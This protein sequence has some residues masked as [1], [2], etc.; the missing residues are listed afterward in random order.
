MEYQKNNHDLE[1]LVV[2]C[3]FMHWLSGQACPC[4]CGQVLHPNIREKFSRDLTLMSW[5]AR[6]LE[7]V[8]PSLRW[9]NLTECVHEFSLSMTKQVGDWTDG[10]AWQCVCMSFLFPCPI[11]FS[12]WQN[13]WVNHTQCMHKFFVSTTELMGQ[14]HAVSPWLNRRV[15]LTQCLH[16]LCE[17]SLSI[18]KQDQVDGSTSCRVCIHKFSLSMIKQVGQPHAA[19]AYTSFLS[20]WSNRWANLMQH[21]YR[22]V[23]S[24]HDQTDGP[25]SC[26]VCVH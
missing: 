24:L 18:T 8:I 14:P 4:H 21:L 22:Q 6:F 3:N 5:A 10:S 11:F 7:L 9:V 20:P 12:A 1:S 15:N 26:S 13:R 17:V 16:A 25:T 23:C 19:F 2:L